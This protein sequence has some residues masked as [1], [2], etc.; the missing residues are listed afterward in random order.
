MLFRSDV[1][2]GDILALVTYPGYDNNKMANSVEPQF[3]AKFLADKSNPIINYATQYKAAPGSTYKLVSTA[4]GLMEGMVTLNTNIN[5]VGT[6]TSI[7]HSPRCWNRWGHGNQNIVEAIHHSCN[8]YFYEVGYR[9]ATRNGNF[10]A[11][12]GLET[13]AKYADLFGL[14]DK[15]GVEIAEYE[16]DISNIDPVR[17]AIGQ[18]TNSFTTVALARYVAAIANSGTT[19]NLTL[20]DNVTDSNSNVLKEYD[21]EVR[22]TI[23][24]PNEYW[25]A[26]HKGMRQVVES[27]SY[28]SDLA[29]NVAGKTGTAEQ[30]S[31]RPNHGLFVSYAP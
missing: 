10:N 7:D 5:C 30:I 19:F 15:S 1:N 24:M 12:E 9:L 22:N 26:M 21:A 17:S 4:A 18:G 2:T 16:P 23:A 6:F 3:Y 31:S 8:Y 14:T 29:V 13:L 25:N 27:K 20:L 28:F 11:A